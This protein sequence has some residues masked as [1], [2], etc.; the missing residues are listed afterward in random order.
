VLDASVGVLEMLHGDTLPAALVSSWTFGKI[1]TDSAID[2]LSTAVATVDNRV[3][4]H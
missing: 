4:N 3:R 1:E 2:S